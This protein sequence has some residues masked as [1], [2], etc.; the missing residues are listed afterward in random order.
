MTKEEL[1]TLIAEAT[2]KAKAEAK[3]QNL[4]KE[5]TKKYIADA[6]A[7]VKEANPIVEAKGPK[8]YLVK[9]K[10][11]NFNGI[12]AGVHF[13]YGKAEVFEGWILEWFKEKGY[14]VEEVK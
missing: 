4:S 13:A 6:V 5:D 3:E 11:K 9:T 10:V 8:K 7:K 12:V 1:K 14:I 2:E